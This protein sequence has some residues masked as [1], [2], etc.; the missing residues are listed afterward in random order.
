MSA[1]KYYVRDGDIFPVL[2]TRCTACGEPVD[3][4][5]APAPLP[6]GVG[7][8]TVS[9]FLDALGAPRYCAEHGAPFYGESATCANV[10]ALRPQDGTPSA[11]YQSHADIERAAIERGARWAIVAARA[12]VGRTDANGRTWEGWTYLPTFWLDGDALG[13]IS[14]EHAGRIAL[15]ILGDGARIIDARAV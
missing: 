6:A 13:I 10:D 11:C 12:S 3:A 14:A 2:G 9:G 15:D 4:H 5:P 1:C 7:V 8:Y